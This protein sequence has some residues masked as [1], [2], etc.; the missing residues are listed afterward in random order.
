MSEK[1]RNV[2]VSCPCGGDRAV[3]FAKSGSG[4][5]RMGGALAESYGHPWLGWLSQR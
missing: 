5:P 4:R 3:V 1:N 2:R